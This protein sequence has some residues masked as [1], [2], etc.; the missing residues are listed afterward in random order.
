[1]RRVAT[2]FF[3]LALTLCASVVDARG[4]KW[5]QL[6]TYTFDQ[7]TADFGRRYPTPREHNQRR[8]I[9]EDR[10]KRVRQHNANGHASYRKGINQFSDWTAEEFKAYNTQNGPKYRTA[11]AMANV[12]QVKY[13]QAQLPYAVDFRRANPPVLTAVKNQGA[14]GSC[15]AHST[16]EAVESFFAI[17][18][19]Q[20]PVLSAQQVTSCAATMDGCGGGDY[21][22]GWAYV[23]GS[24]QGLNE[25]WTFPYTDFFAVNETKAATSTCYDVSSKFLPN[26][27]WVPKANVSTAWLVEPNSAGAAMEALALHGPLSISVAASEWMEYESGVFAPSGA[28]V[29]WAID[30]AVQLVGYGFDTDVQAGY[31][32]VRN[33]WGTT[34][35]EDGYIRL[36][37]PPQGQEPCGTDPNGGSMVCGTC[38]LLNS[39]GFP[40]VTMLSQLNP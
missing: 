31:W 40:D 39:P 10:L 23:S 6:D 27:A 18:F 15:W 22:A 19:G 36:Y 5:N 2:L 37:R 21:F 16:V 4:P 20:L 9:F 8:A 14:C 1:M 26:F 13:T 25:E 24:T 11:A 12:Q 35:G 34:W 3:A 7:F 33:S 28:N 38:G 32:I 17:K 30:H 29:T